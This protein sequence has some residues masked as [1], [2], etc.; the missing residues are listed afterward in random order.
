MGFLILWQILN[1]KHKIN[2]S[3]PI[4]CYSHGTNR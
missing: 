3:K 2:K 1:A 4:N